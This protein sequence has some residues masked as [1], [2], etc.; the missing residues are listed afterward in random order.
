MSLFRKEILAP[1]YIGGQLKINIDSNK[2]K[3]LENVITCLIKCI[4]ILHCFGIPQ[5]LVLS[6][7]IHIL[8]CIQKRIFK[9]MKRK[10]SSSQNFQVP[11][12]LVVEAN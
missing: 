9:H 11:R 8:W 2:H 7:T 10:Y 12:F 1:I 6:I 4:F 5:H 3:I